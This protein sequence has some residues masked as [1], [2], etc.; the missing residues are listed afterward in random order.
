V[1]RW[2]IYQPLP[3]CRVYKRG[4]MSKRYIC[5]RLYK[6]IVSEFIMTKNKGIRSKCQGKPGKY[7]TEAASVCVVSAKCLVTCSGPMDNSASGRSQRGNYI[8]TCCS[9]NGDT[10]CW[11]FRSSGITYLDKIGQ[12]REKSLCRAYT[13]PRLYTL[14]YGRTGKGQDHGQ[15]RQNCRKVR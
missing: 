3:Y 15:A 6:K 11:G 13:S 4:Q 5:L 1:G 7:D 10:T 14:Q 2:L 8:W 9:R 12:C